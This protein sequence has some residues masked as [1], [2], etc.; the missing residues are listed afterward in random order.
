MTEEHTV[1]AVWCFPPTLSNYRAPQGRVQPDGSRKMYT[2]NYFQVGGEAGRLVSDVFGLEPVEGARADFEYVWPGGSEPGF[3]NF[4]RDRFHFSWGYGK[5]PYPFAFQDP[6]ED[7]RHRLPGFTLENALDRGSWDGETETPGDARQRIS[8]GQWTALREEGFNPWWVFVR[9]HD[10][11]RIH[12]RLYL[13]NPPAEYEDLSVEQLP[14]LI[15][16]RMQEAL[17]PE[18]YATTKA[19]KPVALRF[20]RRGEA[21]LESRLSREV[22]R[23]LQDNRNV[24]LSGPPG[25]GKTVA[26]EQVSRFFTSD[27]KVLHFDPELVVGAWS[28]DAA[29]QFRSLRRAVVFHPSYGYEDFVLGVLPEP[30]KTGVGVRVRPGPLLSLAH[31][32][33]APG[34]RA[35]LTLDE[36]NRGSAAAIFGDMLALLDT[37]KRFDPAREGSGARVDRGYPGLTVEVAPPYAKDGKSASLSDQIALPDQLYLLAAMNSSDRSVAPL[38]AAMRRRFSIIFIG[39]DYE[40]LGEHLDAAP[41]ELMPLENGDGEAEQEAWKKPFEDWGV[42]EVAALAVDVLRGI[43]ARIEFISGRDFSLGQAQFWHVSGDSR[44]AVLQ[45]LC[46]A[47]DRNIVGTLRLTYL[48]H[49]EALAAVLGLGGETSSRSRVARWIEPP[50]ALQDLS[51]PRLD[52]VPLAELTPAHQAEA[53]RSL[54]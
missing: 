47:F 22:W 12:L 33:S 37:D 43:N 16:K 54:C 20:D 2:K 53:L 7:D 44:D 15:Q 52:V 35:L 23:A 14:S 26:L 36:F 10:D 42:R 8:D 39:P 40:V 24:L 21:L 28:E 50:H 9:L 45:S 25:T 41:P 4:S 34:C 27:P 51:T 30:T 5:A 11:P 3:V 18:G 32:A 31:F 46:E 19:G 29:P 13:A 48:D 38:D 1:E 6:P 17:P 49:D